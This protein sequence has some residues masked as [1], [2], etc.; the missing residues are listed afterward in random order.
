MKDKFNKLVYQLKTGINSKEVEKNAV[1]RS[2]EKNIKRNTSLSYECKEVD[3]DIK[4]LGKELKTYANYRILKVLYPVLS[5][6]TIGAYLYVLTTCASFIGLGLIGA[7]LL[8]NVLFASIGALDIAS[9]SYLAAKIQ[10]SLGRSLIKSRNVFKKYSCIEDI[11]SVIFLKKEK[12]KALELER[13]LLNAS[14]DVLSNRLSSIDEEIK[15]LNA[16][17]DFANNRF[18]NDIDIKDSSNCIYE[19][20]EKDNVNERVKEIVLSY[21]NGFVMKP[22]VRR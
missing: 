11:K 22:R 5:I 10:I 20:T 4:S 6:C 13:A 9:S 1:K 17:L 3:K 14:K 15:S 18:A 2:L 12:K 19:N 16:R 7:S 21:R 8:K